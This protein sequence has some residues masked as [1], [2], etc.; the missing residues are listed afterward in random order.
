M[1]DDADLEEF[2][3]L[4]DHANGW[5]LSAHY[6]ECSRL[7]VLFAGK[8]TLEELK[9]TRSLLP[10]SPTLSLK[11]FFHRYSS[12]TQ[13]DIGVLPTRQAICVADD[14]TKAGLE[15]VLKDESFVSY[16]P[17]NPST[18]CAL[19]IGEND[20]LAERVCRRMLENGIPITQQIEG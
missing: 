13:I 14:C 4:W 7:C 15:V 8:P 19:L 16:L 12:A 17:V 2:A 1:T 20:E 5:T 18:G 3:Y 6:R 10:L 9:A 11:E